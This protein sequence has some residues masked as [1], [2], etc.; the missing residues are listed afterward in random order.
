VEPEIEVF[1]C[2]GIKYE[3]WDYGI[4]EFR[5]SESMCSEISLQRGLDQEIKVFKAPASKYSKP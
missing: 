1:F 3:I 2:P 5:V 4:K